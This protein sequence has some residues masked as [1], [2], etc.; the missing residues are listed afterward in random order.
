MPLCCFVVAVSCSVAGTSGHPLSW[1]LQI[2]TT[3]KV[4]SLPV[5]SAWEGSL[6]CIYFLWL[7]G[8]RNTHPQGFRTGERPASTSICQSR[9][10]PGKRQLRNQNARHFPAGHRSSRGSL[11][12][13]H[14]FSSSCWYGARN[15]REWLLIV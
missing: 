4:L 9:K 7:K 2:L 6:I 15:R 10:C 5:L 14:I 11:F 3:N 1:T 8:D 12:I 13:H